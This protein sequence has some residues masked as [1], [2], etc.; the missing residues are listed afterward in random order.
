KGIFQQAVFEESVR[1]LNFPT[2]NLDAIAEET[3]APP[4]AVSL[5]CSDTLTVSSYR[6]KPGMEGRKEMQA[7]GAARVQDEK[8]IGL[9]NTITYDGNVVILRGHGDDQ[10]SLSRRQRTFDGQDYNTGREIRY[11]TRT[12]AANVIDSSGGSYSPSGK[13]R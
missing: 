9:G 2:T 13:I 4:G 8:Y 5:R 1:V 10:A 12:G 6:A 7:I 3:A 11:D